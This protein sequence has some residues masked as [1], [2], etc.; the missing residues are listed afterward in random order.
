ML[1]F[2][3]PHLHEGM[4]VTSA[5]IRLSLD[6]RMVDEDDLEAPMLDVEY[7]AQAVVDYLKLESY[8]RRPLERPG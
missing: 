4:P 7:R 5:L 1:L 8:I 3:G 2:L 6:F